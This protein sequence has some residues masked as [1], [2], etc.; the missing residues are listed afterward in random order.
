[1]FVAALPKA[2]PE[3]ASPKRRH[4]DLMEQFGGLFDND[5]ARHTVP[6]LSDIDGDYLHAGDR[7]RL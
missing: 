1:M 3:A 5:K 7:K 6:H 2:Q 4:R